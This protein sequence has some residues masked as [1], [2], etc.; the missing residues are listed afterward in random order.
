M[1]D[2]SG[3]ARSTTDKAIKTLADAGVIV[4]VDPDADPAEGTPARWTLATPSDAD[5]PLPTD[6]A[7]GTDIGD[8]DPGD[9]ADQPHMEVGHQPTDAVHGAENDRPE[10]R[11][12]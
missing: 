6:A 2:K 12:R 8:P 7:G 1:A 11:Q 9:A 10:R 5:A 4:A 3:K